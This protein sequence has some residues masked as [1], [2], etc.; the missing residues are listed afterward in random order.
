MVHVSVAGTCRRVG[1]RWVCACRVERHGRVWIG[2]RGTCKCGRWADGQHCGVIVEVVVSVRQ[3]IRGM[4]LVVVRGHGVS[5]REGVLAV[6][7]RARGAGYW[8]AGVSVSLCLSVPHLR[9]QHGSRR[10]WAAPLNTTT[11]HSQP[12]SRENTP[13]TQA[14]LPSA[15]GTGVRFYPFCQAI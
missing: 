6:W 4:A 10:V 8:L 7:G 14:G 15:H 3:G 1:A 9:N 11:S 12:C 5:N 13:C 2:A